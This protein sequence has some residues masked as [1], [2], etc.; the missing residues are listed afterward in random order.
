MDSYNIILVS[1]QAII[2]F[3]TIMAFPALL[4]FIAYKIMKS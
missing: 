3:I 4:G 2:D 1:L